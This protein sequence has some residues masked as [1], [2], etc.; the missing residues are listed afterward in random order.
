MPDPGYLA[1]KM[2]RQRGVQRG[3]CTMQIIFTDI[4]AYS[5][6]KTYAQ[7]NVIEAFTECFT[8]ALAE[9]ARLYVNEMAELHA[10][11]HHD[12]V[13][14]S[15]GDGVAIGFPFDGLPGLA[16]HFVDELV[17]AV[18]THNARQESCP[19]FDQKS[20]CDCHTRLMVRTGMSE[21]S[22]VLYHDC[23]DRLNIAGNQVNL[24]ARAM[25]LAAPG[26]V[27]LTDDIHQTLIQS[28]PG[29]TEQFRPYYQ[30]EIKHGDRINVHQY[31][32]ESLQGLDIVPTAG[33][34]LLKEETQPDIVRVSVSSDVDTTVADA[35]Q[36][37]VLAEPMEAQ[38]MVEMA[39]TG[40]LM[41]SDTSGRMEVSI[42]KPFCI[43]A[44]LV[45]QDRYQ[46][47]MGRNPSHF[48]GPALPVEM[49][50][51]FDAVQFCNEL[52]ALEGLEPVYAI[53]GQETAVDITRGGYR[54]PT[55][56][57]WEYCCRGAR[58]SDES[59]VSLDEVAW[60]SANADRHTH[61]VGALLPISGVYD[62]LGNVWEWCGDW[63]QR[64]HPLGTHVDYAGPTTG[65]ERVLR[66]GSWRD[67]PDCITP[68]YRHHAVPN[69]RDST[70]GFRLCR[71][72]IE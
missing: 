25:A 33:L 45:T 38:P 21:G 4:V 15:T 64:G 63:F 61:P 69:L 40:F 8:G 12:A 48:V 28:Q 54:L 13:R 30:A 2:D 60:H 35:A 22:T 56:A 31:I 9:T 42:T 66:G 11:L 16:L 14:L 68:D 53:V 46:S 44:C 67:R 1:T 6:R 23:N 50:S 39:G 65:Y 59:G 26:Q 57:E 47:I 55:E 36:A 3:I 52:S 51:W 19:Q 72:R 20:Y 24:A 29:R 41:G 43:G 7:V 17:T 71:T 62:L 5:L 10:H 70:I 32:N 58:Q 34:G 27:F 49:V 18:A 37:A